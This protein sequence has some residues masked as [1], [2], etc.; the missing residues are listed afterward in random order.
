[1]NRYFSLLY[2]IFPPGLTGS[3]KCPTRKHTLPVPDQR[4]PCTVYNIPTASP[5]ACFFQEHG[6]GVGILRNWEG[7]VGEGL[8]YSDCNSPRACFCKEHVQR[9][10]N[11]P[12]LGSLVGEGCIRI[13]RLHL[14]EHVSLRNM[15]RGVGHL[16][17]WEPPVC[18][19]W[20]PVS[21]HEGILVIE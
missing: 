18:R 19:G 15:C 6:R 10:R 12:K 14:P 7:P 20:R 8:E 9:G 1:M 2:F 21:L 3:F 4:S 17:N 13:S 16:Q 11:P 5:R